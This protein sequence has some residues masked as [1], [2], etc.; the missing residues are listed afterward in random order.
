MDPWTIMKRQSIA[1][2]QRNL[3]R[4]VEHPGR[5]DAASPPDLPDVGEVQVVLKELRLPQGRRG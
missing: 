2:R 1:L 5:D 4:Q 3:R